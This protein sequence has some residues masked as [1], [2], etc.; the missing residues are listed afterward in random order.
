MIY[1]FSKLIFL[2]RRPRLIIVS[3]NFREI[4]SESIYQCLKHRSLPAIKIKN[5]NFR[6]TLI[7]V[8]LSSFFSNKFII[9]ESASHN[10]D[11][12]DWMVRKSIL[13]IFVFNN[14]KEKK[15]EK[16]I[17]KI[18]K[19]IESLPS[20]GCFI[21]NLDNERLEPFPKD[22]KSKV[23]TFGFK[24]NSDFRITDTVLIDSPSFGTNFKLNF[25]RMVIPIWLD[26]LF[27]KEEIYASLSSM[28]VGVF[29]NFNLIKISES[30]KSCHGLKGKMRLIKGIK[31]TWVLNNSNPSYVD[32][33]IESLDVIEK[34]PFE[35]RK[36][37]VL[38]NLVGEENLIEVYE[39]V[40]E[41]VS[42]L[43]DILITF[44]SGAKIIAE[45]AKEK[46]MDVEKIFK[47]DKIEQ[48][49]L[50]VQE[51]IKKDD[52]ILVSGSKE[53][54]MSGIVDEIRNY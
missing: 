52:L 3:G 40:G 27:G 19:I 6:R 29:L 44:G 38:G 41:K 14:F 50:L 17:E 22:I 10:L 20:F 4:S 54:K 21:L 11:N 1:L 51:K 34:I 42:S 9:I 12:V 48:G 2:L 43:A 47:F 26:G 45:K 23:F 32:S 36:I 31:K 7:K 49:K 53:M 15:E 28:I 37:L 33:M 24:E 13:P 16:D 35:G 18:N 8:I 25:K 30:L 5:L 39:K 46:G